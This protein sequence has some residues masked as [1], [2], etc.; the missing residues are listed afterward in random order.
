MVGG[1][2]GAGP[3]DAVMVDAGTV[4]AG[5]VVAVVVV[6]AVAVVDATGGCVDAVGWLDPEHAAARSA[7]AAAAMIRLLRST[8]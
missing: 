8:R 7:T 3:V 1:V 5:I 4:E 6:E 2:V